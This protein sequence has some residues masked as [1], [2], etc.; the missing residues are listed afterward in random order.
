[1]GNAETRKRVLIVGGGFAGVNAAKRLHRVD[2]DITVIDRNNYHTFQ[3][4]LYQIA[5]GALSPA[6]ITQPLRSMLRSP[7]TEVLLNEVQDLD[8]PLHRA[9][10]RGGTALEYDF[11]ILATGSTHSYFGNDSWASAAPGLK[12]VEDAI[13]IRRR[14]LLAFEQA[15]VEAATT[16]TLAQI[17]FVVIGGGPTGVELAGALSDIAKRYLRRDFKHVRPE[18]ATIILLEGSTAILKSY[19]EDLRK[20]ALG[21]LARLK[22]EVRTGQTVTDVQADHVV[23]G[24]QTRIPATVVLWSAGVQASPLGKLLGTGVDRQ[25]RILVDQYLNPPGHP[26]VFVCG[27]LANVTEKGQSLPG[28]AQP[29]MQMGTYAA[30]AIEQKLQGRP[31]T[32]PFHYFDK[33]DLAT[34]GRFAAIAN[35]KWPMKMHLSGFFAWFTWLTVHIFFLNG[36]RNRFSVV[37]N[38]VWTFIF[39]QEGARLITAPTD[40]MIPTKMEQIDR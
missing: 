28:V 9:Y 14:V 18:D 8:L 40:R 29:A 20:R 12:T 1:M 15:E 37:R 23:V 27:D 4:L 10:L 3:P 33:G 38:W 17:N 16:G 35:I 7:N 39:S 26:E 13:E 6:D 5:M 22:V 30:W 34:I 19:P 11:L 2:C 21:E 36:L 25:G 24:G 32:K 31:I